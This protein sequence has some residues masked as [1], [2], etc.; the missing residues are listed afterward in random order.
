M[1]TSD[2]AFFIRN[3][4]EVSTGRYKFVTFAGKWGK[5]YKPWP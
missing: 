5:R 3:F 1:E 2:T 4:L